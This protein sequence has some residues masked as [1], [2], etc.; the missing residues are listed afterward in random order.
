MR[1]LFVSS[2]EKPMTPLK[3]LANMAY[4]NYGVS[5]L[6]AVLKQHGHSTRLVVM[7]RS[8][9]KT[10][11]DDI[12]EDYQPDLLCFT[13]VTT[14]FP[15]IRRL[16]EHCRDMHPR[17]YRILGGVHVSLAADDAML[18][19]FNALCIGEG[20]YPLLELVQAL[21]GKNEPKGIANLWRRTNGGVVERNP[22]RELIQDLDALPYP[23][24]ALWDDWIDFEG[25][26]P[27]PTVVLG[28]GCPYLC[29]YCCNHALR[30]LASGKYVRFR[31]PD[32]IIG[33]IREYY[34]RYP[35]I[36]NMYL[37]IETFGANMNWSMEL[38][39]ML[40]RFNEENAT[41]IHFGVNLRIAPP[42]LRHG[43][44]LFAK[45]RQVGFTFTNIGLESGSPRIR[46]NILNRSYSNEDVEAVTTLAHKYGITVNFYLLVGLPD[47]T[48]ADFAQTVAVT[49]KCLPKQFGLSIFSPYPG[50]IL[51]AFCRER[52]LLPTKIADTG[53]RTRPQIEYP[54]FSRDQIR[55]AFV[56]FH[57]YV[58]R[59]IRPKSLLARATFDRY[60]RSYDTIAERVS[61]PL[62]I[63][64]DVY[65]PRRQLSPLN[66]EKELFPALLWRSVRQWP[67]Y[68][69][70]ACK[71]AWRHI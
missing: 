41:T 35:E 15:F 60:L 37:E 25:K 64:K 8:T 4:I 9:P 12:I 58:L 6:S 13:A 50:T 47:E 7:T 70:E 20:E 54:D 42:L 49:K 53:E 18:D 69:F 23:D 14:E 48:T 40:R 55:K 32:N 28:R 56:W 1:I 43:E 21:E 45:M 2:I 19:V 46:Q 68:L 57:F 29:H 3:P 67:A 63:I 61:L 44:E 39:E 24:V 30:K 52:N 5:M 36:E 38:C 71:R 66:G 16:A 31:S 33:E 27:Y 17:I 51:H 62:T 11:L 22:T 10:V 59:E 26:P 34:R 65:S